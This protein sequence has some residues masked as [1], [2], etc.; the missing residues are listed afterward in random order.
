MAYR[1]DYCEKPTK[2]FTCRACIKFA[3]RRYDYEGGKAQAMAVSEKAVEF[4]TICSVHGDVEHSPQT[5]LCWMCRPN[6]PNALERAKL[7]GAS[8]FVQ[9]CPEHG[10]QPHTVRKPHKCSA[11]TPN[12]L[13]DAERTAARHAGRSSYPRD[14]ATHGRVP[15]NT[16]RGTCLTCFNA[17]GY[18]RP[19]FRCDPT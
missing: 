18:P 1:C 17:K 4:Y 6:Q 11:C 14:C 9:A 7:L 5:G 19:A 13:W 16:E 12:R 3:L 8:T 10:D 2:G 15:H